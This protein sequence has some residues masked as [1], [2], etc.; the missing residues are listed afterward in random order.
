MLRGYQEQA[1]WWG[2]PSG[3]GDREELRSGA[4]GC[5]G[6]GRGIL[7]APAGGAVWRPA[8]GLG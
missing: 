7:G 5:Q 2:E 4:E 3:P 6:T 1:Q 8:L